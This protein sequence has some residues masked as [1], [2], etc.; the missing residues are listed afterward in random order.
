MIGNQKVTRARE[1]QMEETIHSPVKT[2]RMSLP[3]G[4]K[5][6][7]SSG[8][9]D[10]VNKTEEGPK[11]FLCDQPRGQNCRS[12]FYKAATLSL[13]T[14]VRRA[15]KTSCDKALLSKI[16]NGDLIAQNA[17]YHLT[18][19]T[20]L[21]RKE[22]KTKRQSDI[23]TKKGRC[24]S[25]QGLAEL[26][27]YVESYRNTN[28]VLH[29]SELCHLY[30]ARLVSLGIDSYVHTSRLRASIL[31]AVPDLKEIR[32]NSNN[33]IDLAFDCDLTRALSEISSHDCNSEVF[34]L[35]Q[36][37]RILRRHTLEKKNNFNGTFPAECQ[38]ESVPP[39][40]TTFMTMLLDGPSI[41]KNQTTEEI[42]SMSPAVKSL[43][44]LIAFNSVKRRTNTPASAPR[45][46][47]DR[48]IPLAIYIAVKVY[49]VTRK[50]C[51]INVL[52]EKGLCIS[53]KRLRTLTTDLANSVEAHFESTG[54]VV[55]L[56]ALKKI[57]TTFAYDNIDH[58]PRSTTC[59]SNF[60]GTCISILQFPDRSNQREQVALSHNAAIN[61]EVMGNSNVAPLLASYT[62]LP[63]IALSKENVD[64][65]RLPVETPL[66]PET[67]PPQEC[68]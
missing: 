64:V 1:R 39:I 24:T 10:P 63:P 58:N 26:I 40:L 44:Q 13:D 7:T 34:L 32:N 57:F 48:E 41:V 23:C 30:S 5:C 19:L 21:Y 36:A 31:S 51:L 8:D 43:S 62:N 46:L 67:R 52:H 53:Y 18:C 20:K 6:S 3:A 17:Y 14:N 66:R 27:D 9:V 4:I 68:A 56:Q 35:P 33:Q 50:E 65:L 60:H 38:E 16:T 47:R 15:A 2:R 37:A 55:P 54:V 45:H 28:T 22:E 25:S 42:P 49:A 29:M 11:C 12:G 59:R 61:Q